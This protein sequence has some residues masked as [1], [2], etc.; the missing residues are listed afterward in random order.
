MASVIPWCSYWCDGVERC[1][2]YCYG[3]IYQLTLPFSFSSN[4]AIL[5]FKKRFPPCDIAL[6][7]LQFPE[8][9]TYF[10]RPTKSQHA[11]G[12]HK[13]HHQVR[14]TDWY[15]PPPPTLLPPQTVSL[16]SLPLPPPI[17]FIFVYHADSFD[18]CRGHCNIDTQW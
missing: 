4:T 18:L 8:P 14:V 3:T 6:S 5:F 11:G 15:S 16:T 17:A 1:R 10:R 7:L 13:Q 12:I 2:L 9:L